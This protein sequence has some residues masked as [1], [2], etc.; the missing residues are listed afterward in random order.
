[1]G[2]LGEEEIRRVVRERPVLL[3]GL[4]GERIELFVDFGF[5]VKNI[6]LAGKVLR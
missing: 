2:L 1:M 3:T 5:D 4:N 6:L